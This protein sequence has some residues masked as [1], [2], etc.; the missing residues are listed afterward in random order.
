M[1][2]Y[3]FLFALTLAW[4]FFATIQDL[5]KREVANWLNFSLIFFA[6]AYRAFYAFFVKEY[7]FFLFGLIGFIL[8][9]LIA[10]ALYY[11]NAFAGGDAKL[12]MAYGAV[13]PFSSYLSL[14]SLSIS[15]LLILFFFGAIYSIFYSFKIIAENKEKFKLEFRKYFNKYKNVSLIS[16]FSLI[17]FL[18]ISFVNL[19]FLSL[20]LLSLIPLAYVYTKALDK[21]MIKLTEAKNLTEGDWLVHNVKIG[22]KIIKKTVHGLS[23]GDI[24]ILKKY[25]KKVLIK[26]GIPFVPAFLIAFSIMSIFLLFLKSTLKIFS[27]F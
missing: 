3:Y 2:E 8:F 14:M 27:L 10:N 25:K 7:E 19:F 15:F 6:L 12:L 17:L 9:F 24:K 11:S 22:R 21:C 1:K 26:Q 18:I 5:K 13:L 20:M 23:L 16:I 4:T